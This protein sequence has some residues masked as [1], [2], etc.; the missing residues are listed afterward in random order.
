[1]IVID[2]ETTGLD[3]MNDKIVQITMIK[4]DQDGNETI[5]NKY[6]NPLKESSPEALDKH[7][8]TSEFLSQFPVFSEIAREVVAFLGPSTEVLLGQNLLNFDIPLLANELMKCGIAFTIH[9]RMILDT[10]VLESK[11]YSTSL[12]DMYKRYTGTELE[13]YHDALADCRATYLVLQHQLSNE[14]YLGKTAEELDEIIRGGAPRVDVGR[15]LTRD[16]EG[17]LVYTFG[18]HQGKR[19]L[20]NAE[21]RSYAEWILGGEFPLDTKYFLK[22]EL[23]GNR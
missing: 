18:K 16:S 10:K 17:F 20:E 23:D 3:L 12:G 5:Y 11:L 21:T 2:L 8:L 22:T 1:M 6:V 14:K 15:R 4:Y 19:V 9:N 7:G 13:N